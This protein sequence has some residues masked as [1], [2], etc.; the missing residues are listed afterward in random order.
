MDF[1]EYQRLVV[2][3][4]GCD[5][6]TANAVFS[7]SRLRPSLND[8]DWLG[9]GIY[10]WEHGP[11]RAMEWARFLANRKNSPVH[12]PAVVGALI[13]L[14]NCFDLLDVRFTKF[15]TELFPDFQSTFSAIGAIPPRNE[16]VFHRLDCAF[17]NWAVPVV[18]EQIG[19]QFQ[20]IRG[21]FVEGSAAF[22]G[23][24]IYERSHIQISVR[25]PAAI[26]GYFHP[27]RLDVNP[28]TGE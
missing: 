28:V 1:N 11:A 3:F 24:H 7:G 19:I 25:D 13:Q 26:I 12:D 18:E 6:K 23:G 5:R 10:F 27:S 2:A 9:T 4:H 15:L 21:V 16:R 14:G 22:P 8:Y 17:L 20:T